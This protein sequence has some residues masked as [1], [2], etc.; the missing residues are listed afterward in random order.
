VELAKALLGFH[1]SFDRSM[2]LLQDVVQ[3]LHRSMAAA[4]GSFRFHCGNRRAVEAGLISVDDA[5]LGMRWIAERLAE[6]AFG[7]RGIAQRRQ[8][9]VDRGPRWNR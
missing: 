4:Q 8:Q 2:I 6:Q 1:A 9:E 5:G 7:R 3:I